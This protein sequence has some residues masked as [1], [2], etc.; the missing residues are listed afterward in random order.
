MVGRRSV[1]ALGRD[2]RRAAFA[3][4][5]SVPDRLPLGPNIG[6]QV[7]TSFVGVAAPGGGLALTARFLQKRGIDTATAVGAVGVDTLPA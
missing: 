7:A 1:G 6:V 2:I 5:G 3:L 4:D